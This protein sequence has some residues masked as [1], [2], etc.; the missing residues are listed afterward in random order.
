VFL[1]LT[2]DGENYES[3]EMYFDQETY[4]PDALTSMHHMLGIFN[5]NQRKFLC[6]V[7]K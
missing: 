7:P 4:A 3:I 5:F 2:N 6:P 1:E